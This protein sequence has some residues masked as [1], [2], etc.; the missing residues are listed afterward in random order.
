MVDM[1]NG[2][3]VYMRLF[4]LK[5]ATRSADCEAAEW[6]GGSSGGLEEEGSG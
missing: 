2:A 1:A 4:A 3:D 5:F 6:P